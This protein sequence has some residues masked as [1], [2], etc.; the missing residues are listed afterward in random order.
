[1]IALIPP[2][3]WFRL[4]LGP[5][6]IMGYKIVPRK[7]RTKY[8]ESQVR[9]T[10]A[11]WVLW[12]ELETVWTRSP[13]SPNFYWGWKGAKLALIFDPVDFKAIRFR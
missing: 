10:A 3:T 4:L 6:R 13:T 7:K 11:Y 12:A 5:S 8:V 2:Q 9:A 1:M